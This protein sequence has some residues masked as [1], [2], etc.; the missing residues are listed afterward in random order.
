ML[1]FTFTFY[2]FFHPSNVE[3]VLFLLSWQRIIPY[4][5]S[6]Q[7]SITLLFQYIFPHVSIRTPSSSF[8]D[9][10][11]FPPGWITWGKLTVCKIGRHDVLRHDICQ[12]I[13]T[14]RVFGTKILHKKCVY[15]DNAKFTTNQRKCFK[16]P[17]LLA[18]VT[19]FHQ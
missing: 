7:I 3:V 11:L 2:K 6:R 5:F 16:I 18:L 1:F 10:S 4:F 13:Y 14:T 9:K 12:K 8:R 17:L 15:C 19:K